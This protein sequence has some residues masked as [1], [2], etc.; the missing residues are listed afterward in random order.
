VDVDQAYAVADI[1]TREVGRLAGPR[2]GSAPLLIATLAAL[3]AGIET[4]YVFLT[5]HRTTAPGACAF[6]DGRSYCAMA[7][8]RL[9]YSPFSRRILVPDLVRLL[10]ASTVANRFE[11]VQLAG[12]VAAVVAVGILAARAGR[13]LG[14]VPVWSRVAAVVAGALC[15]LSPYGTRLVKFAPVLVDQPANALGAWTIVALTAGRSRRQVLLA[16]VLAVATVLTR[17][18]W[19]LPLAAAALAAASG[20]WRARLRTA[21][22]VAT[23]C[24]V[25]R[26]VV[27]ALPYAG[28]QL[29]PLAVARMR[30]DA[31]THLHA[32][33][34]LAYQLGYAVGLLPLAV[35]LAARGEAGARCHRWWSLWWRPPRST[36]PR[37]WWGGRTWGGSPPP[38]FPSWRRRPHRLWWPVVAGS[39]WRGAP[40]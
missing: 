4:A 8:G 26:V 21:A 20:R 1:E 27:A 24:V 40:A 38:P 14:L 35:V 5:T 10:H 7:E 37:A 19:A 39:G 6:I 12:L 22:P 23:A 17:E 16:V 29:S 18:S 36:S 34:D 15:L 3:A 2:V 33:V 25:T 13:E 9:G 11:A 28:V 31:Y 32:L 30:V